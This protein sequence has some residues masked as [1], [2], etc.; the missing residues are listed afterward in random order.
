[1]ESQQRRLGPPLKRTFFIE[2]ITSN[3]DG[4]VDAYNKLEIHIIN[5]QEKPSQRQILE[6]ED[7]L[8]LSGTTPVIVYRRLL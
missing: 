2:D 6:K 4:S 1:M 8:F 7:H 5:Q 3:I